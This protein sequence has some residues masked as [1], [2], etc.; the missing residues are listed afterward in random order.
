ME[1]VSERIEKLTIRFRNL[2]HRAR[3][4]LKEKRTSLEDFWDTVTNL[5]QQIKPEHEKYLDEKLGCMLNAKSLDEILY[6]FNLYWSFIDYSLLKYIIDRFGSPQLKEEMSKYVSDLSAFRKQTTLLQMIQCWDCEC[7]E[8]PPKFSKLTSKIDK[9]DIKEC[10]L[11][12]LEDLRRKFCREFSL[13]KCFMMFRYV[14]EGSVI[15]IWMIP[16]VL[17]PGLADAI[18]RNT[19]RNKAFFEENDVVEIT[20]DGEIFV[21][22]KY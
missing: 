1:D 16:S 14:I 20:V 4:E 9:Q 6:R 15:I 10:K 5:P 13:S 12:V 11:D 17:V 8:P 2:A 3:Q 21:S 22:M 18:R 7:V 19:I